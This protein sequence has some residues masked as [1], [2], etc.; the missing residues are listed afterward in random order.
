MILGP[1]VNFDSALLKI[2]RATHHIDELETQI[3]VFAGRHPY[4]LS[5]GSHPK[6]GQPSVRVKFNEE[7]PAWFA[8]IVGD[9]NTTYGRPWTT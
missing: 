2:Q 8:L 7:I 4:S 1:V 3:S 6:T 5:I 9:A